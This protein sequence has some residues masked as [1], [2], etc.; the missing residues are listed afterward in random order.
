MTYIY[1]SKSSNDY[2]LLLFFDDFTIQKTLIYKRI[3]TNKYGNQT[4]DYH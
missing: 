3:D 1:V 2:I 4:N